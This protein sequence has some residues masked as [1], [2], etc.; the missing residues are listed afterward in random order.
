MPF[1]TSLL[2]LMVL[3]VAI[4]PSPVPPA[5]QITSTLMD[6]EADQFRLYDS[7]Q[8]IE[9]IVDQRINYD[10]NTGSYLVLKHPTDEIDF[11]SGYTSDVSHFAV[12]S[13]NAD[14]VVIGTPILRASRLTSSHTFIFSEYEVKVKEVLYDKQ[15]ES[16]E[17]GQDIVVARV[18][19]SLPVAG[20]RVN[21]IDPEF[22]P[23]RMNEVYVL[24]LHYNSETG[25]F[26]VNENGAYW[27]H[28]GKA[29][30]G[31]LHSRHLPS[32]VDQESFLRTVRKG[33]EAGA[34]Q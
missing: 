4:T 7:A 15:K 3:T 25:V 12:L 14:A 22:P 24:Y 33:V 9:D 16:I 32:P 10:P 18:G 11:G 13:A 34:A 20:Q 8:T 31:R 21:A 2:T 19:G 30:A 6:Q 1:F 27:L 5:R 17:P 29:E 28:D 23:F 26:S